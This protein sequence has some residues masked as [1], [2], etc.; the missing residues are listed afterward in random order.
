MTPRKIL[1]VPLAVGA[2]VLA[3]CGGGGGGTGP[4][5]E[6]T[7]QPTLAP[8]TAQDINPQDRSSL[9]QGGELRLAV[10]ALA[11]NWNPMHVDGNEADL[12]DIRNAVLPVYFYFDA[13]GVA[14]P[15]PAYVESATVT[16]ESPT[17]VEYKLNPK[18]VW[19]D[20]SPVTG[21]DM[22]AMWKACNG[23]NKA[24]NCASTDGYDQIADVKVT[25]QFNVTV[26][27]KGPF[28]DWQQPYTGVV[29]AESIKDAETFNN[30][31][32]ETLD[33]D[34]LSGPFKVE[35]VDQTQKVVTEVP[36]EKWW[37]E[38]PLLDKISYRVVAI[39]ATP[40]AFVNNEIDAFDIG[41]DPN[42][43]ELA[44]G[45][46]DGTIRQAA[47]PSWRHI[48]FNSKAGVLSDLAIRQAIVRGLDREAIGASD[49]ARI[50]WPVQPLNNLILLQNQQGYQ[51]SAKETGID[52]DPERAKADLDAAGWTAGSDGIR[53][54]GGKKLAVKFSALDGVPASQN[55]ALQV[56]NQLREIG[57]KVDIVQV[58]T[59]KFSTT[60]SSG[61][62]EL[63]AF[64]W[65]GTP[66]PY[67][68]VG[69]LFGT[70]SESNYAQLS[71]PEVDQL[72]TKMK[73]ETD[74]AKRIEMANQASAILWTNVHTLPLY[75]R[76]ELI[77]TKAKLANYGA[78][79]LSDNAFPWENVGY[80]Q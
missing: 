79:G 44:K 14:T 62:F 53:E 11:E 36:N 16:S 43:Y 39:D 58:P 60:L 5:T 1:A 70:G 18:A 15:N 41:P 30:G 56:Q 33:N 57:I 72:A 40:N 3:A 61:S 19:G 65:I 55:E 51:D 31:W 8:V 69:Q 74:P 76:P 42:G 12:S 24:F 23:E 75:Q 45:V 80:Q 38:K 6:E 17:V 34:W 66:F 32:K 21:D 9:Q 22:A 52:F 63:I 68:F 50:D 10:G 47:G 4:G 26:S 28:P 67:A 71:L 54:K 13:K 7:G 78:F 25:D 59:D 29:K 49:L 27:F 46:A 2:L 37:G 64:S 48:T 20:G 35:R 77:A 73:T